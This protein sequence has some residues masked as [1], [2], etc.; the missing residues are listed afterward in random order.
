[1]KRRKRNEEEEDHLAL[2]VPYVSDA[3]GAGD[4]R[5]EGTVRR[6]VRIVVY[7][8]RLFIVANAIQFRGS[9]DTTSARYAGSLDDSDSSCVSFPCSRASQ[10]AALHRYEILSMILESPP[11]DAK[12]VIALPDIH[13]AKFVCAFR[14]IRTDAFGN[15]YPKHIILYIIYF[16]LS[17]LENRENF[18]FVRSC[19]I[20]SNI[21]LFFFLQVRT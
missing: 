4:E 14:T 10:I 18:Y 19:T 8:P 16:I 7:C 21:I 9:L 6:T 11:I 1:M 3:N 5:G 13:S 17:I 2:W 12:E 20:V 15:A